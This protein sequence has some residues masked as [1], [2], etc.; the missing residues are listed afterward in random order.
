[1]KALVY[2]GPRECHVSRTCRT[3]GSSGP[4]TRSSQITST[5]ICGSDLHMYEGRT[6]IETGRVL[7]HENLGQVVEVGA[8]VDKV[9]GRR[10]VVLPFNVACGYCEN[11]ERGLTDFCLT[12]NPDPQMAGAAYGFAD[13]GPYEGGQAEYLRV[14]WADFNCLRLPRGRRGEADRLRD[15][16]RHLP[17]RLPRHRDGRRPARRNGGHLRRRPGRADGRATP[18]PSRAPARSWSSTATPT[19]SRWPRRSAPSPI[20]DSKVD[21]G[22]AVM[23]GDQRARAPTAAASASATRR[24]TRRATSTRTSR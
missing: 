15:A 18:R 8:A 11:C 9:Q 23:R 16:R 10:L 7:G 6:D 24:T 14:P 21:P 3:R 1:M 12:A 13:M 19:G 20:D 22:R 5:N 4:P 17:H 2:D